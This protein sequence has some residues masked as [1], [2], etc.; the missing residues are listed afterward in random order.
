LEG[1][2]PGIILTPQVSG[3]NIHLF[4]LRFPRLND[5]FWKTSM[6]RLICQGALIPLRAGQISPDLTDLGADICLIMVYAHV[7]LA[8]G[9]ALAGIT[10]SPGGATSGVRQA[11]CLLEIQLPAGEPLLTGGQMSLASRP[12]DAGYPLRTHSHTGITVDAI[13]T[14]RPAALFTFPG[15]VSARARS[16]HLHINQEDRRVV[17]VLIDYPHVSTIPGKAGW[18]ALLATWSNNR[19]HHLSGCGVN[20]M[21]LATDDIAYPQANPIPANSAGLLGQLVSWEIKIQHAR[22]LSCVRVDFEELIG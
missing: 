20:L 11:G 21:I 4:T 19:Q 12:A 16:Q 10:D 15:P 13:C 22:N 9:L 8:I 3:C 1:A 6:L 14:R 17:R 2:F 5:Q 7:A 18:H